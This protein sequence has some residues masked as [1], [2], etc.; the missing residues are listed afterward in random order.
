MQQGLKQNLGQFSLLVLI[1]GF[2]GAMIGLER[3]VI[4]EFASQFFSVEGKTALLSFIA[5]FGSSKALSNYA[6]GYLSRSFNRKTLLIIGWLFALPVSFLLYYAQSWNWVIVANLFLGVSQG[7]TWSTAVVMKIDLVGEKNRGLAM[8][9]NEFAGYFSVGIISFAT[10]YI[11][12]TSG[13]VRQAFLPGIIISFTGLFLSLLFVKDTG[14]HVHSESKTSAVEKLS[15]IWHE[16]TWRHKN[17]G[18]VTYSGFINNLNDGVLWGLLP[19]ILIQ[20]EFGLSEIGLLAGIYPAVWGI[21][22]LFTGYMG[23]FFCKKKLIGNGMILQA[24][25]IGLILLAAKFWWL[26]VVLAILGIGTALVYP[27]FLAVVAENT[28]PAQRAE[29]LGIFRFWRDLGYVAGAFI[30]GFLADIIG[31]NAAL[32]VTAVLTLSSGAYVHFKMK[33]PVQI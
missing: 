1:N 14:H 33:C 28:H 21:G 27:N 2:V 7:L 3:S 29:S 5:A 18:P 31:L 32:A 19:V 22:Q 11:S 25:A 13:D 4:P 6:M 12:A 30:G 15:S 24:I 10:G 23:D 9:L 8:G 20:K 26:I 17:L 16:T